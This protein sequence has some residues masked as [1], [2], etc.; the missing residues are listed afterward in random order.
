MKRFLAFCDAHAA[1]CCA[2]F[3]PGLSF[4]LFYLF[5]RALQ[6]LCGA[7]LFDFLAHAGASAVLS[8]TA[9]LFAG[10]CSAALCNQLLPAQRGGPTPAG[11]L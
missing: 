11:V 4:F 6:C 2:L 3:D 10:C 1:A 7:L 5:R 9:A 8:G